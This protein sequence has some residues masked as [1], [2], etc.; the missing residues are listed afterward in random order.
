M[1][2]GPAARG[3]LGLG[4]QH[5]WKD[6]SLAALYAAMRDQM[7]PGNPGALSDQDYIDILAA[8][9][10]RNEFPSGEVELFADAAALQAIHIVWDAP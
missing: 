5:V 9:L 6:K 8:I 10:Q 1:R 2:G 7:P 4:F 3:L